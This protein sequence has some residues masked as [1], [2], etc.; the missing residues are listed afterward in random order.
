M[1]KEDIINFYEHLLEN[2]LPNDVPQES[3]GFG[4]EIYTADD[5]T[6]DVCNC[7]ALEDKHIEGTKRKRLML[8]AL[9]KVKDDAD[10]LLVG[11][12]GRGLD[13]VIS[14]MVKEWDHLICYDHN[15]VYEEYLNRYF[16]YNH[17]VFHPI[18]SS[19][20]L[21]KNQELIKEKCIMVMNHSKVR[22][23]DLI[24]RNKNIVHFIFD[25][26]LLW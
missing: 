23:F 17:V 20:F 21:E 7:L 12:V 3:M 4:N 24:E 13:I 1:K 19:Y 9:Q 25:G 10:I 8:K 22:R 5:W 15:P 26:E 16:Y 14:R 11:E 6:L 2:Q 18:S